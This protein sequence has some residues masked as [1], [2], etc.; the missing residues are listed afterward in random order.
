MDRLRIAGASINQT[1]MDWEG[2]VERLTRLIREAK[3]Q[4]VQVICFP[5]LCITGYNCEDTFLSV[6]T[7]RRSLQALEQLMQETE[8]M[9]RRL[10]FADLSSRQHVQLRRGGAESKAAGHQSEKT[11]GP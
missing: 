8:G 10:R 6:H 5:E 11:A 9:R 1:P 4:K 7:A 3:A 2:N